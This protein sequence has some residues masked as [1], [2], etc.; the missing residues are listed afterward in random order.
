MYMYMIYVCVYVYD[1][2]D[3]CVN[4]CVYDVCVYI[5]EYIYIKIIIWV[6]FLFLKVQ[7]GEKHIN[8]Q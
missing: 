5:F 4:V 3:I 7:R 1:A 6:A 8:H 2:Y